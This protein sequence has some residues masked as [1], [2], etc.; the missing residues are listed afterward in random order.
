M[1]VIQFC[2][3]EG[4][5]G[6]ELKTIFLLLLKRA[7]FQKSDL[8]ASVFLLLPMLDENQGVALETP[9]QQKASLASVVFAGLNN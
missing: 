9:G 2:K 4:M 8:F 7:N 5:G 3:P 1:D 6:W